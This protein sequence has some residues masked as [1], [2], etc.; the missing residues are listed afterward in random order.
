MPLNPLASPVPSGGTSR[1]TIVPLAEVHAEALF[2]G[3]ADPRV[4]EF[5]PE[6]APETKEA[7]QQEV[8]RLV[9]GPL[10]ADL[11]LALNWAVMENTSGTWVGTL[12][13]SGFKDGTLW[14]G[15]KF[16]PAVWGR[17]V[18]TEAVLWLVQELQRNQ[19]AT[20]IF[21]SVDSRHLASLGVVTRVGFAKIRTEVSS[22]HGQTTEDV[23][24]CWAAPS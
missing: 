11:D 24:L 7:Y 10:P 20:Q 17:G 15:Y 13:A 16:S 23:I 21:A 4:Y 14:I 9:G 3:F 8:R 6:Q 22:L 5:I 2:E 18:A 19:G 12:Q 1:L